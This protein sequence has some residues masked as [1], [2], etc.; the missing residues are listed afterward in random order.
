M[1]RMTRY[2]VWIVTLVC[3]TLYVS[4]PMQAFADNRWA[5]GEWNMVQYFTQDDGTKVTF[6]G[7]IRIYREHHGLYGDIYFD[8]LGKW[9][10]LQNIEV[11][12][13]TIRFTRPMYE[14][15]FY[16]HRNRNKINGTYKDKIHQGKW[17]WSAEKE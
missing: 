5:V 16:G 15:K 8:A 14:Q 3:L 12:D 1:K 4:M 17:Q 13:E 2:A 7:R 6:N 11:T 10:P 9:E